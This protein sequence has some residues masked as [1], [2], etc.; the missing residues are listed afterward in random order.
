M[1]LV[2]RLLDVGD[3]EVTSSPAFTSSAVGVSVER[4]ATTFAITFLPWRESGILHVPYRQ[5]WWFSSFS[6]P[7]SASACRP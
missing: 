3:G 7:R 5:W 6:T 1:K 4:T 2:G